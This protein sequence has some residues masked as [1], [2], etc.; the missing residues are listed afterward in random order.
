MLAINLLY[1]SLFIIAFLCIPK[2]KK[3]QWF[4]SSSISIS[5]HSWSL[6]Q[7]EWWRCIIISRGRHI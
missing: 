1:Y 4:L 3:A 6:P 7:Q 5:P 2:L